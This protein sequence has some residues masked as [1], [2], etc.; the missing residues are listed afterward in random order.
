[1]PR[2]SRIRCA[3]PIAASLLCLSTTTT[4][5]ADTGAY[6]DAATWPPIASHSWVRFDADGIPTVREGTRYY[7]NPV[8]IAEYGLQEW[9]FHEADG[10][11]QHL[12]NA[13]KAADWL[14]AHQQAGTGTWRYEFDFP[15]SGMGDVTMRAPWISAMAQGQAMSLLARAWDATARRADLDAA[16]AALA[17]FRRSVARGGVTADFTLTGGHAPYY[18]EYP[19][20]PASFTLNGFM[21][22]LIGLHDLA[23]AAPATDAGVL[24]AAGMSTLD[25]ALP[26][27]D[28]PSGLSIYHLGY[29]TAAQ[30]LHTSLT[31]HWIH[32]VELRYLDSLGPDPRL[33]HYRDRWA[34]Y[35]PPAAPPKPSL[36]RP[37]P[38]PTPVTPP[39]VTPGTHRRW[40][41]SLRGHRI[42]RHGNVTCRRARQVLGRKL[43][44]QPIRTP[45][46]RC[47]GTTWVTCRRGKASVRVRR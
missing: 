35:T 41:C 5:A 47:Y 37:A 1:V 9:T 15:V 29:L 23:D 46:W 18:E 12:A 7:Y 44:G 22:S 25:Q 45:G 2:R 31:Y 38:K 43:R 42:R 40:H 27:Y 19:T 4:A 26:L 16:I 3:L 21:F 17:P 10:D 28:T 33:E 14:V 13:L 32:V 36:P 6:L 8:T 20:T 34:A 30:P 39:A 11:P 24:Y